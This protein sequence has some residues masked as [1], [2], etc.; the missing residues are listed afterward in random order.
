M[1]KCSALYKN[2]CFLAE[3]LKKSANNTLKKRK[4]FYVKHTIDPKTAD[5]H[6]T[7]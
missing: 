3:T 2:D 6:K 1:L 5:I 4:K 7:I